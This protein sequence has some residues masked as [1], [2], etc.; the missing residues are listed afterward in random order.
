MWNVAALVNGEWS[1]VPVVVIENGKA[2]SLSDVR[3]EAERLIA[4]PPFSDRGTNASRFLQFLNAESSLAAEANAVSSSDGIES[5]SQRAEQDSLE[6]DWATPG[7]L[8]QVEEALAYYN[9]TPKT[10]SQRPDILAWHDH[11]TVIIP[12]LSDRQQLLVEYL[13]SLRD[14]NRVERLKF[15]YGSSEHRLETIFEARGY[16]GTES[17]VIDH[18]REMRRSGHG[19]VASVRSSA[20]FLVGRILRRQAKPVPTLNNDPTYRRRL[21]DMSERFPDVA[22]SYPDLASISTAREHEEAIVFVH[23]TVS[24]AI[25]SL[26]DLWKAGITVPIYRYEHDTFLPVSE[27]AIELANLIGDHLRVKRLNIIAH[28]RGGLVARIALSRLRR[29]GYSGEVSV[30][31]FG[32][33]HEGTPLANIGRSFVN[34]LFKLGSYIAGAIPVF[35]PAVA[36]WSFVYDS[37]TLPPGIALMEERSDMLRT[38]NEASDPAN[39]YCWGS[40]FDINRGPSGFGIDVEGALMGAMSGIDHDLVVPTHSALSFGLPQGVFACSHVEYF[41][42]SGVQNAIRTFG[43]PMTLSATAPSTVA[44]G[45]R[46]EGDTLWIGNLKVPVRKP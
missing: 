21:I 41:S 43:L 34:L 27:N 46:R 5:W 18:W 8:A 39:V 9:S 36:A 14:E 25:Q 24:C 1:Q 13:P 15:R 23:G 4:A 38:L 33:P 17:A 16:Y 2:P 19:Y 45:T 37:P 29:S 11:T 32:T 31:T 30:L 40:K 44:G 10:E 26:K 12:I 3:T 22:R 6:F 7:V 20:G 42:D 28:S 35:S